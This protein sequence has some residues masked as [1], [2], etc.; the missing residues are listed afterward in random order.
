MAFDR[1]LARLA[2]T[3][4]PIAWVRPENLHITL[5]FLGAVTP[6]G[7]ETCA[8]GLRRMAAALA[9]FEIRFRGL[10]VF[11]GARRATIVWAGI[12]ADGPGLMQLQ[13]AAESA[14][15]DAGME[16]ETR[17]FVPHLTIG[18]VRRSASRVDARPMLAREPD[19]SAGAMTVEA[20][21]L[22]SSELTPQ[23]ARYTR[24]HRLTLDG[25]RCESGL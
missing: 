11:P 23:G 4:L 3:P 25:L 18:R 12:E 24:L 9:P 5:R 21:S 19:F 14:A 2:T 1:E 6:E 20:V 15:R 16:P 22:F 13:S 8:E 17:A 10:G 7:A